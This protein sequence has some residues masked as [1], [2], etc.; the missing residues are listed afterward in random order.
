MIAFPNAKI[1][2][3]LQIL[4]KRPDGYH[5]IASLFW[6]I[7]WQDA[8]EILPAPDFSF[9]SSG[10]P[11]PPDGKDNLCV[12][13]YEQ[14][15]ADFDLPP[16]HIHLHK[17]LPTGAGLGGGS[18]DAAFALKLLNVI[19]SLKLSPEALENYAR[20][21]GSDCA[22]FIQNQP[23]LAKGKGDEWSKLP[24]LPALPPFI[25]LV[26]PHQHISS[27][28][29]YARV[30]PQSPPQTL[31]AV[32]AQAPQEWPRLLHNDFEASVLALYPEL[33]E[34]KTQLYAQGAVYAA[35]T[36]SGSAFFGLFE[37]AVKLRPHFP[38]HYTV[39]EGPL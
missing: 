16:V 32:L 20:H 28:E 25:G 37:Q 4:K 38:A 11:I 35:M 1:N 9:S 21:L 24:S 39:W 6:P 17:V 12:R 22:F 8:L 27:A 18:S 5:D 36:G 23:R 15:R 31:E 34:I 29:A 14:L 7:G 19:F 13:A 30:K 3:G 2:L 10:L 33:A 26:F